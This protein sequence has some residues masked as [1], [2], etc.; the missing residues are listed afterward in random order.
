MSVRQTIKRHFKIISLLQK[1]AMSFEELQDEISV[2]PD[3]IEEKLLT[4][5]RTFQRDMLDIASIYGI[6]ITSDKSRNLY[7]IKEDVKD[8]STQRL[9]ENYDLLNAIRLSKGMGNSLFFE[10]RKAL[11]TKHMAGL[12]YAVQN[13]LVVEFEY[14]K[15]W[16]GS[17]SQRRVYPISLKEARNRWYLIAQDENDAVIKN[18]SLDRIENL[19][20]T[21]DPF[22]PIDYDV[23]KEF[24]TSFGIING[25]EEEAAK[26]ILSF[27]PREGRYVQSLPL[28]TSQELVEENDKEIKFSYFIRP[29]YDFKMEILSYGDQVKVVAPVSLQ[30]QI[31]E[32]LEKSIAQ[33]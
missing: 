13:L 14:L 23:E 26:V 18:F 10:Q 29:T 31:R 4:S 15:F 9:R 5:Q 11:G 7:Y 3:S 30:Q 20:L 28:H 16:D 1:K 6:E 21:R 22:K 19:N 33:Y 24:E 32:Q 17:L 25:T 27:T 8:E 12:L 2:D